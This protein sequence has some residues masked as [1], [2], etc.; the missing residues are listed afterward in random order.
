MRRTLWLALCAAFALTALTACMSDDNES[1]RG[2]GRAAA[3][4]AVGPNSPAEIQLTIDGVTP[5]GQAIEVLSYSWGVEY[6]ASGVP[7]FND[8]KIAKT[9]DDSSPKLFEALALGRSNPRAELRLYKSFSG[10]PSVNYATFQLETVLVKS[11]HNAGNGQ[12]ESIPTE[13]VALAYTRIRQTLRTP[14]AA[15]NQ[16]TP[17]QFGWDLGGRRPW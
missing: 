3:L 11:V 15:G 9:I 12:S 17:V 1:A 4:V 2:E 8:L 14:D 16:G 5:A 10:R 6:G 13:E 7:S